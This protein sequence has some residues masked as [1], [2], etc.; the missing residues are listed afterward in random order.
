MCGRGDRR[1]L[2]RGVCCGAVVC[3]L[4][5]GIEISVPGRRVLYSL[6]RAVESCDVDLEKYFRRDISAH[7]HVG[8]E[9]LDARPE[10]VGEVPVLG[11]V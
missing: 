6:V 2:R 7:V 8:L 9:V 4:R 11:V 1:R 3:F 10:F 5:A